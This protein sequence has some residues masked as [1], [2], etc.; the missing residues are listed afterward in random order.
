MLF[1]FGF[2][3]PTL[4]K[5]RYSI[6]HFVLCLFW[7]V[8]ATGLTK[9]ARKGSKGIWQRARDRIYCSVSFN[10]CLAI[11]ETASHRS[12]LL[13]WPLWGE[14]AVD[15]VETTSRGRDFRVCMAYSRGHIYSASS[16]FLPTLQLQPLS[17][18]FLPGRNTRPVCTSLR[19]VA[20]A[21]TLGCDVLC[22]ARR[23]STFQRN[24]QSASFW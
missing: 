19:K 13:P 20:T 24:M 16:S 3:T 8:G 23:L 17:R 4:K 21:P 15:V 12:Y 14:C 1:H 5:I 9:F 22:S 11:S 18:Y 10:I 7:R 6:D 2:S